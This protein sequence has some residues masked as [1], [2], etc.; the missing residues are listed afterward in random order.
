MIVPGELV[1]RAQALQVPSVLAWLGQLN[2]TEDIWFATT[3]T[4]PTSILVVA[5]VQ[6]VEIG[7][8]EF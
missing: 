3:V 2:E 4:V 7:K 6:T 8:E 1:K 5:V